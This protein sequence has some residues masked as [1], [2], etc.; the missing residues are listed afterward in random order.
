MEITLLTSTH[1][2]VSLEISLAFPQNVFIYLFFPQN[3]KHRVAICPRS[4]TPRY[5]PKGIE[6]IFTPK[7]IYEYS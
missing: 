4:S 6:N 3:A 5:L 7:L 2:K 1:A